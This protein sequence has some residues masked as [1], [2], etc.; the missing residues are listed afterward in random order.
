VS[1]PIVKKTGGHVHIP[2]PH[3]ELKLSHGDGT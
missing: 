1:S 3:C 2:S